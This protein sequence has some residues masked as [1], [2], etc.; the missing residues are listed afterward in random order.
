MKEI[1]FDEIKKNFQN[2]KKLDSTK[3]YIKNLVIAMGVLIGFLIIFNVIFYVIIKNNAYLPYNTTPELYRVMIG[4]TPKY[5]I[6]FSLVN[7]FCFII[8]IA[9]IISLIIKAC[10][11]LKIKRGKIKN[12]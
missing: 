2:E 11:L 7:G 4:T 3:K 5:Y 6:P 8:E 10:I 9:L 12:E 1:Q